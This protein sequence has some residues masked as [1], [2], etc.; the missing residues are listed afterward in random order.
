[1]L[2]VLNCFLLFQVILAIFVPY[3]ATE[4]RTNKRYSFKY[5]MI[6]DLGYRSL[7]HEYYKVKEE[8]IRRNIVS[9]DILS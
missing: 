6:K 8:K 5:D 7:V 2:S 1:M 4:K 9:F 3:I